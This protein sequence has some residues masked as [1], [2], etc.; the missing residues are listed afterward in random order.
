VKA[1]LQPLFAMPIMLAALLGFGACV[2]TRTSLPALTP[3]VIARGD[4]AGFSRSDLERGR[5]L[6][7][8]RCA[9]CHALPPVNSQTR[10]RWDDILPRMSRK[11]GLEAHETAAVRAFVLAAH[12]SDG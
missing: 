7:A 6:F 8:G 5:E 9:H 2:A 1:H 11:S 10:A 4:D 3:L 12:G